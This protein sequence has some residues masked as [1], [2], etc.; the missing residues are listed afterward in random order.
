MLFIL[1]DFTFWV[2]YFWMDAN[3]NQHWALPHILLFRSG[4]QK[5]QFSANEA[6][7]GG[8]KELFQEKHFSFSYQNIRILTSRPPSRQCPQLLKRRF[9]CKRLNKHEFLSGGPSRGFMRL[10]VLQEKESRIKPDSLLWAAG[11]GRRAKE[12]LFFEFQLGRNYGCH[13]MLGA[14]CCR[15]TGFRQYLYSAVKKIHKVFVFSILLECRNL[16]GLGLGC[17]PDFYSIFTALS[18]LRHRGSP[19][20]DKSYNHNKI[21]RFKCFTP[22][23]T[24]D[25]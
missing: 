21:V 3:A 12:G 14:V 13:E 5:T 6:L 15:R 11:G 25:L 1:E 17:S 22:S 16:I 4:P 18:Q 8:N 2:Q 20:K 9:I 7:E 23:L 19:V 10:E 24:L